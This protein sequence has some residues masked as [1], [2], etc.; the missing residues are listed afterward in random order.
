MAEIAAPRSL[1]FVCTGNIFRS[2]VAEY[3]ARALLPPAASIRAASAGIEAVPQQ[4]HPFVR[5]NLLRLNIDASGH[6]QRKLSED[7]ASS[8][9]LLICFT[10][11]HLTY[12]TQR[13]RTRVML[14]RELSRGFA[15]EIA[16][17]WEVVPD[18]LSHPE[19][20]RAYIRRVVDEI[21]SSM[22]TVLAAA[23][24]T[25]NRGRK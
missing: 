23:D 20:S 3:S 22:P 17:V 6:V 4:I 8:A 1:I 16:D 11:T 2:M 5:E 21:W 14:F 12:I 19:E 18:W 13:C 15:E 9:D 10:R 7:L 24:A 25:L